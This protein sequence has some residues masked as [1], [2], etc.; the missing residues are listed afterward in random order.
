MSGSNSNF[1]EK[2]G[3]VSHPTEFGRWWQTVDEVVVEVDVEKG[4]RGKEV[5]VVIKPS[6]LECRVKGNIIFKVK[7]SSLRLP[8]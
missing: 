6:H 3:V 2:S 1:D 4:T 8:L 5:V 7:K